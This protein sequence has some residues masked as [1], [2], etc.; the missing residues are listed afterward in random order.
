MFLIMLVMILGCSYGEYEME[1]SWRAPPTIFP[2]DIGPL[3][4]VVSFCFSVGNDADERG[5]RAL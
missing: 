5:N 2:F 4:K 3:L 1:V